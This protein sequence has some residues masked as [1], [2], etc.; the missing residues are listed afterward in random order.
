M[1][2]E[3]GGCGR[4]VVGMDGWVGLCA[5]PSTLYLPMKLRAL[6][7]V[8]DHVAGPRGVQPEAEACRERSLKALPPPPRTAR[9]PGARRRCAP[10][11]RAKLPGAPGRG[12][13][14]AGHSEGC[15]G[16]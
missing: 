7:R 3:P 5:R 2:G 14:R 8:R 9:A 15:G 16:G 10:R 6:R 13:S 4:S 11:V 12:S 1:S